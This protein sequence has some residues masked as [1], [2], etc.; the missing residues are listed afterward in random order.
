MGLWVVKLLGADAGELS[1][2]E[3]KRAN[4]FQAVRLYFEEHLRPEFLG[5]AEFVA[6]LQKEFTQLQAR[7]Q[8]LADDV[9]VIWSRGLME[10]PL[11]EIRI[12]RLRPEVPG[13]PFGLVIEHAL[14][15]LEDGWVF[16]KRNPSAQGPYE[17]VNIAEALAPYRERYG[18][19]VTVHRRRSCGVLRQPE[20]RR[21]D[22]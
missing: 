12:D 5:P 22:P 6:Y 10:L 4:C 11:G 14:V 15:W 9:M 7:D 17:I 2:V 8:V 1:R 21:R 19:E 16:Q 18:F 3:R 20:G 13:Y